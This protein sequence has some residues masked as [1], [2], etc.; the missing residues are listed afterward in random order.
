MEHPVR[1][2]LSRAFVLA[3]RFRLAQPLPAALRQRLAEMPGVQE[4]ETVKTGRYLIVRYDVLCLT[5]G[6]LQ[7]AL[8]EGGASLHN[9]LG[10]RLRAAWYGY[11]DDNARHNA[12]AR[13]G[14]C[15]S[16]PDKVYLSR[17]K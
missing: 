12:G 17:H 16:Q 1:S 10:Q 7:Q 2:A 13:G 8:L 3:R 14:A 6:L 5:Y 4:L 9:G 11:V 15:C